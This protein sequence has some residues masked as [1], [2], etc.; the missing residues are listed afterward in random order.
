MLEKQQALCKASSKI[1]EQ[2]LEIAPRDARCRYKNVY[3][4]RA[5]IS[6]EPA[7][8][9]VKLTSLGFSKPEG[10]IES[11]QYLILAQI[12][13]RRT[14]I[15]LARDYLSRKRGLFELGF[16][17][18]KHVMFIPLSGSRYDD[19]DPRLRKTNLRG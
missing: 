5:K 18:W 9:D 4:K 12:L 19:T 13:V 10:T 11:S 1:S 14:R 7:N 16:S 6:N 2:R 8:P 17:G 15:V 3:L